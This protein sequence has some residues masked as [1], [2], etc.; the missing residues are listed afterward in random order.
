MSALIVRELP[1]WVVLYVGAR[2][3]GKNDQCRLLHSHDRLMG[4]GGCI[5]NMVDGVSASAVV[6]QT[7]AL[8]SRV[9]GDRGRNRRPHVCGA[10][11]SGG[12]RCLA[13]DIDV[14]GPDTRKGRLCACACVSE[15][16]ERR[17]CSL[18]G[19][20]HLNTPAVVVV[21]VLVAVAC[22]GVVCCLVSL[23]SL[24]LLR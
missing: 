7:S 10:S 3:S 5:C 12:S 22:G 23:P 18:Q 24:L 11:S 1:T 9:P 16:D 20:P 17:V 14:F 4:C 8:V 15:S 19:E 13:R 21:V 6:N 2:D